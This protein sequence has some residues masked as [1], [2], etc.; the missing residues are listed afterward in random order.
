MKTSKKPK[1]INIDAV[2]RLKLSSRT[3]KDAENVR[4]AAKSVETDIN[5]MMSE[6]LRGLCPHS[7]NPMEYVIVD[8]LKVG[9]QHNLF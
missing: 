2:L 5:R 9:E 4:A 3:I 6:I 8:G 7:N 1:P